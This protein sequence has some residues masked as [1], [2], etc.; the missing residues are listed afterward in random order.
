MTRPE[1]HP[2]HPLVALSIVHTVLFIASIVVQVILSGGHHIPSPYDGAAAGKAFFAS[3]PGS[4][5]W[6]SFLQFGATVPLALCVVCTV[7]R[8][9][10]LVVKAAGAFI[11]LGG[12]LLGCALSM[13]ASLAIWSLSQ[14]PT[15]ESVRTLQL[16]SYAAGD[17]VSVQCSP[18]NE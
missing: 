12:G 17:P 1:N 9:Q 10:F 5:Q 4:V 8:L 3:A 16:L 6:S 2:S 7:S 15:S 11:A 18:A 13:V 14:D